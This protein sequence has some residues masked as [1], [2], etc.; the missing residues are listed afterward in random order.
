MAGRAPIILRADPVHGGHYRINTSESSVGAHGR[1]KVYLYLRN[2]T[3]VG[4]CLQSGLSTLE[5][6]YTFNNV[7]YVEEGY[8]II[9]FYLEDQPANAVV[10][11]LVT[12][13]AMP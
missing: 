9:A 10:K 13:E 4:L 11:D 7:K 6:T 12:P 1:Y 8:T 3:G 5:G 2:N